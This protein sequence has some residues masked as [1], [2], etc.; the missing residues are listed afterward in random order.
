L[1]DEV[2]KEVECGRGVP[3]TTGEVSGRGQILFCG[4]EM[5]YFWSIL[6]VLNL[7]FFLYPKAVTYRIKGLIW[8]CYIQKYVIILG[9]CPRYL[10]WG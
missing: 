9:I 4:V 10:G 3:L 1:G 7:K 2:P 6:K 5:A 8:V